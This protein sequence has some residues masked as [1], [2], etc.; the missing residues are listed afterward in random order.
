MIKFFGKIWNNKQQRPEFI[1]VL[2]VAVFFVL[3]AFWSMDHLS[4][5]KFDLF[6]LTDHFDRYTDFSDY[7]YM[8]HYTGR[9]LEGYVLGDAYLICKG[10]DAQRAFEFTIPVNQ[11]FEIKK[12]A[13]AKSHKGWS[14][15]A[16]KRELTE[17]EP[18]DPIVTTDV[19]VP[20][21]TPAPTT[22]PNN[23]EY[24]ESE[25][26]T[27]SMFSGM[28]GKDLDTDNEIKE[29]IAKKTGVRVT[30]YW[31]S[32]QTESEAVSAIMATGK[33]P[34][35]IST[36]EVQKLYE[37]GYLVA[38][39]EYLK[40]YPNLK[41][42]YSD[43]EWDKFRASD[44]HI[45]WANCFSRFYKKDTSTTTS[46]QAFWIQ[47]RVLEAYGYPKIETLDQYFE[48]LE[49]YAKEHPELPNGTKVI[50][51]TC[52]CEDWRNFCLEAPP[53]Y[54]D[55]APNNGCVIVN[56]DNGISTPRVIDYNM[57]DTAKAYFKKL[58]EEYQKGI[59][60]P[61]FADQTYEAGCLMRCIFILLRTISA[62]RESIL[63]LIP[64]T[65]LRSCTLL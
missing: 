54:L 58:N 26:V 1:L 30:E 29:I 40:K 45:Y 3:N 4:V 62:I 36:G 21:D 59:V 23:K 35:F 39:D 49:K 50:P 44:G 41:E 5:A 65:C 14:P 10:E 34:D 22:A 20:T 32:A 7:K 11:R 31:L 15:D 19:P 37:G 38:W 51:Y 25:I 43:D 52:L 61:A 63:H 48:L 24:S 28:A 53:M 2:S 12:A 17:T 6:Y 16:S 47:A 57:T 18:T 33:L 56:V 8:S 9:V 42:L 46:G 27:F 64:R 60:D 55:G 13:L